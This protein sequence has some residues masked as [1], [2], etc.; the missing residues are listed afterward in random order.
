MRLDK[1][2]AQA[3]AGTRSEVKKLIRSGRVTLNG[4]LAKRPEEKVEDGVE[5]CID[6]EIISWSEYEY[7]MLNKPA[8]VVSATQDNRDKTVIDLITCPH[9]KELFPVG[10]LDK[11][12][13][14]FLLLTNDG[15]LAHE[16]LSPK[17]HVSKRYLVWVEGEVTAE[18]K[19]LL[20]TGVD[21]GDDK[22]TKPA[23]LEKLQYFDA[24]GNQII[25]QSKE[26][27]FGAEKMKGTKDL[28]KTVS[29]TEVAQTR[30]EIVIT[31]GRYHQIKR[32]FA[33]T[34]NPVQYLKR[35]SMG[36]LVL[37]ASLELGAFRSLTEEEI[38]LLKKQEKT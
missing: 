19:S 28:L 26:V 35:L 30:L 32:M 14:G 22:P 24:L 31:E 7:F 2:L 25:P 29:D 20:E 6:G 11:D 38:S 15:A 16:L 8:G 5:V 9:S 27:I 13:E 37:D 12:T 10:R 36:N 21:I 34:G 33:K 4:E 1:Y 3:G 17:K 23:I 18:A